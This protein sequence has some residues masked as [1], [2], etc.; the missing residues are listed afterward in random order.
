ME[1]RETAVVAIIPTKDNAGTVPPRS[2]SG[3]ILANTSYYTCSVAAGFS[4]L[5]TV[6]LL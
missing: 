3:T 1:V 6:L 2:A 5:T 4:P